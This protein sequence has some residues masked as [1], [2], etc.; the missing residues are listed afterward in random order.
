MISFKH[1]FEEWRHATPPP[2]P[3][4]YCDCRC[5]PEFHIAER[6]HHH[7]VLWCKCHR[8]ECWRAMMPA[9]SVST[10]RSKY[11]ALDDVVYRYLEHEMKS[12]TEGNHNR[13]GQDVQ[14]LKGLRNAG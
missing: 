3:D 12:V 4:G 6:E 14:W 5:G 2:F 7:V 9:A 13:W 8:R 10:E 1:A 11:A